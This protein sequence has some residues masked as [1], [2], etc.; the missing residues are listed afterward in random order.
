M[1]GEYMGD[2]LGDISSRRGKV[3][4]MESKGTFEVIKASVPLAELHHYATR[5][6][7]LTQGRGSHKQRFSHYE[8]APHD[9][10]KK[11][12]D[13]YALHHKVEEE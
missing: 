1:P 13:T 8:E 12:V 2:V 9:F 6:R 7:S 5:L 4:G 11:V 3:Q 10:A